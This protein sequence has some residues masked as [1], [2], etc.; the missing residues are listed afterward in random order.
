MM[1]HGKNVMI[2]MENFQEKEKVHVEDVSQGYHFIYNQIG[3]SVAGKLDDCYY[4]EEDDN[5]KCGDTYMF[6]LTK[7]GK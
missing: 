5:K 4:N 3:V 7:L 6:N 2:L 1:I